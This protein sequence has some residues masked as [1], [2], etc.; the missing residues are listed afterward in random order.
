VAASIDEIQVKLFCFCMPLICRRIII[1]SNRIARSNET[2]L[3][4]LLDGCGLSAHQSVVQ[5]FGVLPASITE[6]RALEAGVAC[7]S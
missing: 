1:N 6:A 5:Q 4:S 7:I 3:L 2:F